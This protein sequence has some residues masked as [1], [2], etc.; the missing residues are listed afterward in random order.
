MTPT[1]FS[2]SIFKLL[3][4]LWKCDLDKY[5]IHRLVIIQASNVSN[6][7]GLRHS[8]RELKLGRHDATLDAGLD[9]V[10]HVSLAVFALA[11]DHDG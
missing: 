8:L 2:P 4:S 1:V 3:A 11:H 6:Q 10:A 9:F 5:A 7:F